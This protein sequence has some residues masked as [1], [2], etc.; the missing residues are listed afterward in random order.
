[1]LRGIFVTITGFAHYRDR[2][3]FPIGCRLLCKKEPENVFDSEA[4]CVM[5][6]GGFRVGYV[7]NSVNTRAN[8]TS[9]AGR[10]Y[11]RVGDCFLV[12]VCFS[13]QTKIICQVVDFNVQ[14]AQML[15]DFSEVE[16]EENIQEIS[17]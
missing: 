17:F 8:G 6:R 13:T 16:D 4:I 11:D 10:I 14:D 12:E 5:A 2:S 3:P 7:A 1:M 9:S 15:R